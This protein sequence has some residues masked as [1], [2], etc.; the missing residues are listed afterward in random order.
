MFCRDLFNDCAPLDCCI[1]FDRHLSTNP[2]KIL[3]LTGHSDGRHCEILRRWYFPDKPGIEDGTK[4]L[5]AMVTAA[6]LL[7]RRG[8]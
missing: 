5:L 4:S 7:E 8:V 3:V 1:I 2:S 6:A